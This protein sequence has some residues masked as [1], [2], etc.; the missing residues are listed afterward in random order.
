MSLVKYPRTWHLPWSPHNERHDHKLD[1]CSCFHGREVV[2]TEKMDGENT[3]LYHDAVHARSLDS[4]NHPSRNWIKNLWSDIRWQ[5]PEGMRICGENLY[6]VHSLEY[7]NLESYFQVFNIW[8]GSTCLS[9]DDTVKWC[10][11][12][13]LTTVPLL[14]RGVWDEHLEREYKAFAWSYEKNPPKDHEGYVVRVAD[15]FE[16]V[17][18][19]K[20]IAKYV[21]AD[22]IQ[23]DQHW[24]AQEL[25]VNGLKK[26]SVSTEAL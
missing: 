18:W 17:D 5:I 8:I 25:R 22:H 23:T 19:T 6:A 14:Y 20:S 1:D 11:D 4:A 24:M 13:K 15:A 9:W 10:K 21:R 7:N 26:D 3:T 16:M 2:V 12:L